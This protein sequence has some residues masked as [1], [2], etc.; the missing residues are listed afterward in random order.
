[1]TSSDPK[2]DKQVKK[3]LKICCRALNDKKAE[4]LLVLDVQEVSSITNFLIIAT[5]NSETHLK[6]LRGEI[7]KTLKENEVLLLGTESE[8]GSGWAVID[9][10]D[11]MLHL[12]L[13]ETRDLYRLESLWK[14]AKTVDLNLFLDEGKPS[15]G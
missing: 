7:D 9:A 14:D 3:L 2:L 13:S 6:A 4:E 8:P 10:F 12:F 15:Q 5:G 11:V 1:M